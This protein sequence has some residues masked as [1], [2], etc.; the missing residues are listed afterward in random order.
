[1]GALSVLT[2]TVK[3]AY[4]GLGTAQTNVTWSANSDGISLNAA[5]YAGTSTG[6]GGTNISGSMTNNSLGLN[7]SLSVAAAGG[8]ANRSFYDNLGPANTIQAGLGTKVVQFGTL[9]FFPLEPFNGLFDGN[10]TFNTLAVDLSIS[11][12]TAT[13]SG[14][15]SSSI[16]FGIYTV[17][18]TAA[19]LSLGLL[20]SVIM[21]WGYAGAATN[22]STGWQGQRYLTAHSSQWSSQPV[23]SNGVRYVVGMVINSAGASSAQSNTMLGIFQGS[24]AA[25]SGFLGQS[26]AA[27]WM[28]GGGQFFGNYGTATTGLPAGVNFT[29]INRQVASGN[30]IPHV[31]AHVYTNLTMF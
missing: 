15:L 3:T 17:N 21:S 9:I 14:A 23:F 28:G 13:L 5:G 31:I 12:S 8:A 10:M 4:L 20:N 2:G 11:G 7:L 27:T 18:T 25:R 29:Q 1:M 30:F 19:T 24:T 16:R 6:F 26:S 22:N